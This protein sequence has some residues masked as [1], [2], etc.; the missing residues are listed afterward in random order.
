MF[1][2]CGSKQ[3][4]QQQNSERNLDL[5]DPNKSNVADHS[6]DQKLS[7]SKKS[8][9]KIMPTKSP[10]FHVFSSNS[11]K[12]FKKRGKLK[13]NDNSVKSPNSQTF[14]DNLTP[15]QSPEHIS[16]TFSKADESENMDSL[17]KLPFSELKYSGVKISSNVVI[18]H[19]APTTT[20]AASR[21]GSLYIFR[22]SDDLIVTPFA[23]ILASLRNVRAN[24][25]LITNVQSSRE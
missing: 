3:Q 14:H 7:G 8:N 2:C 17:G 19:S 1:N 4:Q 9:E 15:V 18:D 21:R 12:F 10:G 6:P 22:H 16:A 13:P 20:V 5:T 11:L 24:F 25:I 23:Q